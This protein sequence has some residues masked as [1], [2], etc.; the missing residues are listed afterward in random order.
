M[1]RIFTKINNPTALEKRKKLS[2][3]ILTRNKRFLK[4]KQPRAATV[5]GSSG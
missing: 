5:H 1:F 3:L 2:R 4:K